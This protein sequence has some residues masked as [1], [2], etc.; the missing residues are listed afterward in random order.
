M[1]TPHLLSL[2]ALVTTTPLVADDLFI[3]DAVPEVLTATRL[4]QAPAAVPG[5]MTVLDRALIE[6][7]GARDIPEL[8]RL[9][10]GM[11]VGYLSGHESTVNYHGT[12]VT[13]ARRMQVL[14]DGRS[15]YRPGLATVDWTDIPVAIEDI[16][17]IEV[18][19][20]PNSVSYGANAL[21]GVINILT[22]NPADSSGTRLKYTQGQRGIRDFYA[23]QGFE[24]GSGAM[25]LS[26]SGK[27]DDGFDHDHRGD[28]YRDSRRLTRF[29]L[30]AT[31]TLDEKQSIDWQL[32]AKE[33]SNQE[34]YDYESIFLDLPP[35]DSDS[36]VV[37]RDYAGSLRWN[38]D[39]NPQHSLYVQSNVQHW[40]RKQ[41]WRACEGAI[42]F[43]PQL[44][45]LF[46]LGSDYF[47]EVLKRPASISS[48]TPQQQALATQVFGQIL[49]G[50]NQP[51][52]GNVNK[53]LRETR[54]DLE[55]QDTYSLS[56]NLRLVSGLSYRYDQASSDTFF[57]GK[58]SNQLW[59]AFGHVEWTLGEH[60]V[61]QGGAMFE[62]DEL[63][64][65]SLTP[66][67]AVNY[68]ITPQHGLR[69]V[70]SEAVRS[71]DMYEN[72]VDWRYRIT[73]LTPTINGN[74][75]AYFFT[76]ARGPGDLDQEIMRSR[77][78]GYNGLFTDLGLAVDVKLFY[79]EIH[80][81]ISAPL[82][83]DNFEPSND[84]MTRFKGAETQ[85]DWRLGSADRLR[86]TYAY[87]D[88]VATS[89]Q[90]DRLTARNSGSAGWLRDWGHGWSSSVFYYG[91]DMLNQYRFERLDLRLA[92][93]IRL[94]STDLQLAGVMQQRLD[95]EPLTWKENLYDE[96]RLLY[97]SAELEF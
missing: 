71:A 49:G 80:R 45:E 90:D 76:H 11:M 70:Y 56:D 52:C 30:S 36:D 34:P 20:G 66:R 82:Q 79:D 63:T 51:T 62:D 69:A 87:V 19:R 88:F 37:A 57:N 64:D 54:Y 3:D 13:E 33:G 4:K 5:S 48:G 84:D 60:W 40:E 39:L 9:V 44:A 16:E 1:R 10:P 83:A 24:L 32:A 8:M 68:L 43:S 77:E 31:H 86:L 18:F 75:S 25:R 26:L 29:N 15:V 94:G 89:R 2:L 14:I 42:A 92:K 81:M 28:D 46:Q 96:R 78:L 55:L 23:S 21:M 35:G 12:N 38:L 91:A 74:S 7:T 67:L 53:H 65:S 22:R 85:L 61:L 41:E 6:A 59:R 73:N 95:D 97:L 27:E 58:L 93:R 47:Y 50:G 17:R 72:N